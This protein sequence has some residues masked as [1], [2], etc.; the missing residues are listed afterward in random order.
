[1]SINEPKPPSYSEI[2]ASL[3]RPLQEPITMD[4]LVEQIL[5]LRPSQARN[6]RQAVLQHIREAQGVSLVRLDPKTVLP[7]H[8]AF[9]GVRFRLRLDRNIVS[10]GLL[11][12]ETNLGS[13]L[14][15]RFPLENIKLVDALERP[16][17][18]EIKQVNRKVETFFGAWDHA[19]KHIKIGQWFRAQKMYPK[20]HLLVTLL[21]WEDGVFKIER[22]PASARNQTLLRQR[23][24]LLA[25]IL[26]N[27]LEA[28]TDE[29]L[30]TRIAVPT[31][32]ALLPDKNGYPPDHWQV[33]IQEDGRME[34]DGYDI[35][36]VDG[37]LS[38]FEAMIKRESGERLSASPEKFSREQGHK[39]YRLKAEFAYNPKIWRKIEI[40]G[41]QTLADLDE[42]LRRSFN[43]DPYDH[44]GGFWKLIPRGGEKFRRYREVSLGEVYPLR[45]GGEAAD[46]RIAGVRLNMGDKLKYVYDFGDWIEHILT[47]ESIEEPQPGITYPREVERNTPQYEYCV[48][49]QKK[50]KETIAEWI[51]LSCSNTEGKN[52]LLCNNCA[53]RHEDDHYLDEIIY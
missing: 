40:Q 18:F 11:D 47:L 48:E 9:Q 17:P 22:E 1:M 35:R 26:W 30:Y 37:P 39:I 14:P 34:T 41:K 46:T 31:A 43:H 32:Y 21:D 6:P 12:I 4:T 52:I 29:A 13:Y 33:V 53:R 28:A 2:I 16:I 23:N 49:C 15:R 44:L 25:N 36:Y 24:Q 50:G 7:L 51:C 20:D 8:L 10:T 42:A 38:M 19:Q 5:Q 45:Q 3:L 27:M